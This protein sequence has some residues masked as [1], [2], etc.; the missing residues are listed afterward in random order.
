[1]APNRRT[2]STTRRTPAR[3]G[4]V[5]QLPSGR[6]RAFYRRDGRKFTAPHTFDTAADADTWLSTEHADRARGLWR[7]PHAGRV[8]LAAY[9]RDWLATR[10]D[11]QPRTRAIYTHG[12]EKWV[13][14]RIAPAGSRGIDLGSVYVA[15]LTPA[16][17]RAWYAAVLT[18]AREDAAAR[19][20]KTPTRGAHPARVWA[21]AKGHD[22]APTGALSPA[23]VAAWRAAGE[24]RITPPR[25]VPDGAGEAAAANAYR[26]LRVIL[27]TAVIDDLLT[28]NPCQIKSAGTTHP[29]ERGVASPAEVVALAEHM[30]AHLSAAVTVAAWSG[31]RYGELF[32]LARRHVDLDTGTL[33][34]ERALDSKG[35]FS[36]PKT[37]KSRRVVH[38]P[39]TVRDALAAHLADH[40]A[41]NPDALVFSLACGSPVSSSRL[42][43]VFRKARAAVDRPDLTWH[44]LRHT[45]ATLAYRA[46]A[47]VPEVQRRLGHTTMRAAQVYA[48]AVDDSDRHIA[49]R[50]DALVIRA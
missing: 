30:P 5:E 1:M 26:V 3:N 31:L 18:S 48:H 23:T 15:D 35:G 43:A 17:V 41:D 14:P 13:L 2:T 45:G 36:R 47:S 39:R 19:A 44:D 40:V 50:L 11:L 46:G 22:I 24:P 4:T 33:R 10:A 42:S 29:R 32:A 8:T 25:A 28:A 38:L 7:D 27:A 6:W 21:L 16:K 9:A 49:D 12:L 37:A 20:A 34:V